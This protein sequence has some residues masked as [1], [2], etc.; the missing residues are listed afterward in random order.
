[1]TK[2]TTPLL[3]LFFVFLG[4]LT[5]AQSDDQLLSLERI[6][7]SDE[8]DSDIQ[9][10]VNWING[11]K[12]YI[13]IEKNDAGQDQLVKYRSKDTRKSLYLTADQIT[14]SERNA[15]LT[16]EDFTLSPDESKVLIFTNSSRVWRS[17]TKGDYWVYDF[18]TETLSQIGQSQP[19]SSLMFAKFSKDNKYVAYVQG[20]NIYKENFK[21]GEVTQLTTDGDGDI[22]NGTFDWAYEEEFGMRDGFS[23]SPD[24]H[25]IAF[26]QLDASEIGNFYMINNT[27]SVY[28]EPVPMQYPKVGYDPSSAKVGLVNTNSKKITW[29]PVPGD[30]VQH[31]LPAMQWVDQDLLLIQQLN[32]KQNKL[33]I[34]TYRPSTEKLKK[35]YTETEET[36]VDLRYPDIASVQWGNNEFLLTNDNKSL[37][38]M[39]E[40]DWRNIYKINLK[41]GDKTL[42]TPGNYD[43]AAYYAVDDKKV[44]FDASPDN[45]TQRYLYSASLNGEG[46][47]KRLTP[48]E[49][50]G[51]NTYRISPD[52]NFALH[53]HT[54]SNTPKTTRLVTLPDHKTIS[55]LV[56]NKELK[57]NLK[58]LTL[59]ETSFFKVTTPQDITMDGRM[60]KPIN[61]DPDKD[62]PVIFH[63]YGEP[64]S[65]VAND[66]WIGL[67]EIFLAQQGFVVINMD[68]RG[69]PTL[70]GS[71]WRKSIYRNI[72]QINAQDQAGAA[73][74]V[75]QKYDF[76][77][78]E[79]VSVWGWSG[80]GSM[81]QN[82][83]FRYPDTYQTGVAVAGV[84][85]QLFYDNIYQERYMGLPSEN[86]EDFIKGSPVTYAKGLEGNL[87]LI[88]GTG[89][90][91]VHYQNM[92]YLVN[93]L[94]R[95]DKQFDMMAYPNR[96]HHIYEGKNTLKHLY[97]LITQYFLKHNAVK[98]KTD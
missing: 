62:Y 6:H 22:I 58:D 38:R 56:D 72:G 95:Q 4:K 39:V 84:A 77:D 14:A 41:T 91:N 68:N 15:S 90:D 70:K 97:T 42:L 46:N 89:D 31:Y 48:R 73:Q 75:L 17:N 16:I 2:L 87:L 83:L 94:I 20:F 53:S 65:T 30:P 67:Y 50:S 55:V 35:I 57:E 29:I 86:K 5:Y 44:Y 21:T 9:R 3:L 78:D 33:K 92:E 28:S 12:A 24:G 37:L 69:A 8:F 13:S 25:T 40:D 60:T 74:K 26:W 49:Y 1:M 61:F 76:I 71:E 43:V 51:I 80:G 88:H 32:R 52:A 85:N 34:F 59:P 45:A 81:T 36:W 66:A 10:P 96:T 54:N 27:D 47:L 11:G 23:W 93:E 64:W 7:H 79:R 19:S 98:L 18:D 63:V 82:L